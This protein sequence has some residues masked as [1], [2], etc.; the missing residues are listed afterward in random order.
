VRNEE[1]SNKSIYHGNEFIKH[2]PSVVF[3][4]DEPD[5]EVDCTVKE[6]TALLFQGRRNDGGK[7]D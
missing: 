6:I 1:S 5:D 7:R 2:E 4:S 3:T